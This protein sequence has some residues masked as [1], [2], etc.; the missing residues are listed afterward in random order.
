M[1]CLHWA[2]GRGHVDCVH[3]LLDA[4]AKVDATDKVRQLCIDTT[5]KLI[6]FIQYNVTGDD[7]YM[8]IKCKQ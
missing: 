2:A 7:C 4:G 8:K 5:Y 6:S 1:T 3:L